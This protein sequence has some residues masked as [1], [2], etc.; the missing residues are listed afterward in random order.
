MLFYSYELTAQQIKLTRIGVVIVGLIV[1][2][3]SIVC[4]TVY[5]KAKYNCYARE[6]RKQSK[7][8]KRQLRKHGEK[9]E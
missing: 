8:E 9:H 4:E 2:A 1:L 3:I 5:I 7:K 6:N